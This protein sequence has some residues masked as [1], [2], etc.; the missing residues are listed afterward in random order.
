[1]FPPRVLTGQQ[2]TT[3]STSP[4]DANLMRWTTPDGIDV[5]SSGR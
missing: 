3:A 2:A 1:M 4:S 5:P